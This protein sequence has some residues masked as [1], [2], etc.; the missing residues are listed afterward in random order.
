MRL[1]LWVWFQV[2]ESKLESLQQH[3]SGLER[4]VGQ[5]RA[6]LR[7]VRKRLRG[8]EREAESREGEGVHHEAELGSLKAQ[9]CMCVSVCGSMYVGVE[10]V[11]WWFL[12]HVTHYVYLQL[13][14]AQQLLLREAELRTRAEHVASQASQQL[15]T[16][17]DRDKVS[18]DQ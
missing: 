14:S 17:A 3:S 2:A 1:V 15:E 6:E 4:E 8:V 7:A 11:I 18:A 5:L 16:A 13:E 12:L 9:V 10:G